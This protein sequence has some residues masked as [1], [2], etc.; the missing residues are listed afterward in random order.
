[1]A[2]T[3]NGSWLIRGR[4]GRL[5]AYAPTDEAVWCWAE[6]RPGGPWVAP[7]PVGG[8]QRLHPVL[9]VGQGADDYAHLVSW[10]P[11][12]A[13]EAGLVH[14]THFRPHLAALDWERLGHPNTKG[15]QT[16]VPAVTVDAEGRAHVFVRNRGGGVSMRG[17]KER[18][19]WGPW[20]DLKGREVTGELAAVTRVSGLVEL[21]AATPAG[22]LRWTQAGPGHIPALDEEPLKA[23]VRPGTLRALA[24]SDE[25]VTLFY[26]DDNDMVCAWRAGAEPAELLR[27]AGP[28]PVSAIRCTLDGVDCTLLAQRSSGGRVAFAAYPTE[29][30]TAGAWWTDSGPQLPADAGVSLAEDAAGRVVAASLAPSTGALLLTHRKPE[31]GLALE[32]WQS[33]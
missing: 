33:V 4:D 30:E 29:Q 13:D 21:Y 15:A 11:T 14:S 5:S 1:M 10:R 28:G 12:G 3:L 2:R 16:G 32:A 22:I 26:T 18:G 20:R 23:G 17:Q 8:D 9:A 7:R 27:C 6:Q 24:T 31:P 19:G 25:H